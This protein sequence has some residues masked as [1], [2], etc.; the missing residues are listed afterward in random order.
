MAI[1]V[2]NTNYSG[3]VLEQLLTLAATSNEIV[4]KGLIMVIP[5]VEKKISLPRLKTGKMLQK[6]KENPGVE[7]SKG[8][9]NYDEKSLDP[10]DF[11]AFT[12][13]NPRTFENIWRK[14]Q[15]KGNLV[16]SELPPEAQ[17]ALLA[18]LAKRVQFEL[19]D[20]YVNGEYGDDAESTMLGRLKAMRAK[21]PVAIRNNPDLRILMSVNDFDKYDD[22]LTQRE[23]KNTSETDVNA[24]RYKGIT[25]ETLAAWPDDLIVCTLCSPDAGGNLFAA[26]NLQDDEDVIQIDKISNASELYFFKMLMKADTNI[27][28]GEEVVVLDKRSN[29]VFKAS[30]KKISV[31]PASVTL[32]ATGGSEEVTVT[33]SGEY[34]IGSAPAGFKVE[35]TDKGVKISAGANSGSQKTG[36]LTLTLNAD[37]SKTAKITIT[38][39]QKG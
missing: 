33:A 39:N 26:V 34:E 7:D 37:R 20:H 30:E 24:R 11:M 13:F 17:N 2:R 6:R 5:G 36:T 25:I 14:W 23:S 4:E 21:I 32:E 31:D 22:E 38:Q 10:V 29:P 12:V 19:G 9:F 16:F 8:N 3:E 27:A 35:A 18:E 1:I 28:F 15:P